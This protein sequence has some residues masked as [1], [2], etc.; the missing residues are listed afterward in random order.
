[1]QLRYYVFTP[2]THESRNDMTNTTT[3]HTCTANG[4][5]WN[6]VGCAACATIAAAKITVKV[7]RPAHVCSTL[8]GC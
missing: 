8:C 5:N 3:T 4:K 6:R 1:M 2:T 7:A